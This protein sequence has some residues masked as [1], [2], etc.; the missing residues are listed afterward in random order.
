MRSIGSKVKDVTLMEYDQPHR[1]SVG[2]IDEGGLALPSDV[3]IGSVIWVRTPKCEANNIDLQV[4]IISEDKTSL[5]GEVFDESHYVK[6][7]KLVYPGEYLE[8]E[9]EGVRLGDRIR[10]SRQN[11]RV[12][13]G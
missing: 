8:F 6:D 10:M 12:L 2:N 7:N 11:V 9:I 4:K 13:V 3:R 5:I 1:L